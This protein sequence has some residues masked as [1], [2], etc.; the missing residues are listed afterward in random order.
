MSNAAVSEKRPPAVDIET[1]GQSSGFEGAEDRLGAAVAQAI[2]AASPNRDA[3]HDFRG[4][5]K[6]LGLAIGTIIRTLNAT[7]PYQHEMNDALVKAHLTS[8]EFAR[9]HG[10]MG[11]LI[12]HEL[13]VQ[14]PIFARIRKI[15][16]DTGNPD[17]ALIALTER[18]ACF[19]HLVNDYRRAP[20][21]VSWKS[22]W[23]TVLKRTNP[24][25]QHTL[26]DR[27]LHERWMVPRMT[28]QAEMMGVKI[29]I[30]PWRE[31]GMITVR[32]AD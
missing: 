23:L 22:P 15:V 12:D 5:E 10:L 14:T 32:V 3:R 31:D 11:E 8:I 9:D 25:G 27:E 7:H 21:S 4:R 28:R 24:T 20:G 13:K 17:F 2:L 30:S 6:E 1:F 19:Y 18:T 26:T 16:E 29:E